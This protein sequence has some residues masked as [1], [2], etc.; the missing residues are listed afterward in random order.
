MTAR[1]LFRLVGTQV[2][3]EP[4]AGLR[5]LCHVTDAKTSYGHQRL[6][7]APVTGEGRAWVNA[8]SVD[9]VPAHEEGR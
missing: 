7:I 6:E 1:E 2:L 8:R 3:V 9:P 4:I 5:I